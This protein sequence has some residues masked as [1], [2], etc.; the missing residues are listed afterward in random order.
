MN[1]KDQCF[2][3]EINGVWLLLVTSPSI[4]ASPLSLT[5]RNTG[6]FMW[7][8]LKLLTL[9]HSLHVCFT[10]VVVDVYK[11]SQCIS[12]CWAD[13]VRVLC[14]RGRV[15]ELYMAVQTWL[16]FERPVAVLHLT[17]MWPIIPC[18]SIVLET[19]TVLLYSGFLFS[20]KLSRSHFEWGKVKL[21]SWISLGKS[22]LSAQIKL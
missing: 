9:S 12:R 11:N 13:A 14:G 19:M 21:P 4:V 22:L 8:I 2:L 10:W 20:W 17:V 1:P 3:Y 5:L 15:L 6:R 18:S 16:T 7:H